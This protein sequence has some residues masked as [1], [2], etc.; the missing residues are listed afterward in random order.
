MNQAVKRMIGKAADNILITFL[1]AAVGLF[2]LYPFYNVF[3]A[4]MFVDGQFDITYFKDISDNISL[5]ENSLKLGAITTILSV[6]SSLAVGL[7]YYLSNNK[8][9]RILF[10]ILGI[11]MISPP[12]VFALS[13]INLF[14][15]RGLITYRLLGLSIMPYGMWGVAL[16]QTISFLSLNSLVIIS[17]LS[18]FD[19]AIINSARSLKATTNYIIVDIILP[20][21]LPSLKVVIMLTFMQSLADFGTPSII[22]GNFNT[23]ATEGYLAVIAQGNI[24][25]AATINI[26]I[27]LPAMLVYLLYNRSLIQSTTSKQ[28]FLKS[29]VSLKRNGIVYYT[30][31]AIAL[32]FVGWISIQYLSIFLSAV[33]RMRQGELIFTLENIIKTKPYI[34]STTIR[35]I[36]YSLISAA[37]GSIMGL[38]IGYY[39]IIRRMR[40]MRIVDFIATLPYIIP[41]TFFGL[42]YLL[43]FNKE[44]LYLLGTSALIILNVLFKQMPFSTKIGSAMMEDIDPSTIQSIRDLGGGPIDVIK[45]AIIPLS[46]SGL[47]V[48]FVNAF[49]ATMTTIGS[50]IFLIY[51]GQK[52]LTIVMFDVIQSGKYDIGSVIAVFII[53]ICLIV[54]GIYLWLMRGDD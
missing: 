16:M 28:G 2:I 25:K 46:R 49:T 35:S 38:L 45:D 42:G 30:I 54:N 9:K 18:R 20:N 27:L 22:G 31:S 26:L 10:I 48:S 1:V 41:G 15:R 44:P 3:K 40:I 33:T 13:Y 8:I 36:V 52:V 24:Q 39:M 34:T 37:G 12:F 50:I 17:A 11:S 53:L 6:I 32:F 23:L 43:A 51:P 47:A 4:S 29:G 14:G 5:L 7:F 21:I 19:E